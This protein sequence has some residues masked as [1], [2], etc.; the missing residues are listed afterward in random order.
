MREYVNLTVIPSARSV[1]LDGE[2]YT[3]EP[4][5]PIDVQGT[6]RKVPGDRVLTIQ[7][8][9]EH[10]HGSVEGFGAME[11][12]SD[13]SQLAPYVKAW[14]RARARDKAERH[15]ALLRGRQQVDDEM[16]ANADA[17]ASVRSDLAANKKDKERAALLTR[18]LDNLL[19]EAGKMKDRR[20]TDAAIATAKAVADAAE[21]EAA[22]A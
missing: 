1:V 9:G 22:D 10:G 18:L 5:D 12:F 11:G 19:A 7:W 4:L 16:K 20:P 13:K 17:M 14:L 6:V 21:R 2:T 15:A 8:H 3:T